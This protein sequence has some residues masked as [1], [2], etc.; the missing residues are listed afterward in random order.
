MCVAA[1]IIEI[2]GGYPI[3]LIVSLFNILARL[4]F[5]ELRLNVSRFIKKVLG[6][7]LYVTRVGDRDKSAGHVQ[8]QCKGV[9]YLAPTFAAGVNRV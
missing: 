2:A 4:L 6:Q 5:F 7:R 3:R 9:K 8:K 1:G